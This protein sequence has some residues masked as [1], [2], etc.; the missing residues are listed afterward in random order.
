[1]GVKSCFDY[2]SN[3]VRKIARRFLS[4]LSETAR[5]PLSKASFLNVVNVFAEHPHLRSSL[6]AQ[7]PGLT[8]YFVSAMRTFSEDLV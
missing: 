5:T 1:M 4:L 3:E 2:S 8:D 6:E 7:A